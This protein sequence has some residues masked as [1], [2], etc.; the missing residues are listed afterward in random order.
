M[1]SSIRYSIIEF[2]RSLESSFI[3]A[4]PD[5]N[6]TYSPRLLTNEYHLKEPII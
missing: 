2:S 3:E 1:E 4:N 5:S 6:P